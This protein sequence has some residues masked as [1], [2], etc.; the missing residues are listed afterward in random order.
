[1]GVQLEW[2]L[3][4]EQDSSCVIFLGPFNVHS[5]TMKMKH[6]KVLK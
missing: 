1:M 5:N 4:G 3:I 6:G 2:L